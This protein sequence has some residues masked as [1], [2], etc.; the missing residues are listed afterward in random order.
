MNF[1]KK[2]LF[3]F[4]KFK[5]IGLSSCIIGA[6]WLLSGNI[7]SA[8]EISNNSNDS[9]LNPI[10]ND[11]K[12]ENFDNN[13]ETN[14]NSNLNES[15]TAFF[16]V[17][18]TRSATPSVLSDGYNVTVENTGDN[19]SL[20]ISIDNGKDIVSGDKIIFDMTN[21]IQGPPVNSRSIVIGD[22][23]VAT[24]SV[25]NE[26]N[27][28]L[29]HSFNDKYKQS[30]LSAMTKDDALQ[31]IT[32]QL[33]RVH[34]SNL[35]LTF[36]EGINNYNENRRLNIS[37]NETPSTALPRAI[38]PAIDESGNRV[39]NVYANETIRKE[40]ESHL[41][42]EKQRLD[43]S[44]YATLSHNG[45]ELYK[46]KL[47]AY[48]SDFGRA[49]ASN[50][51]VSPI[52][53]VYHTQLGRENIQD[54]FISEIKGGFGGTAFFFNDRLI[55]IDASSL[56]EGAR[57]NAEEIVIT[58]RVDDNSAYETQDSVVDKIVSDYKRNV[59]ATTYDKSDDTTIV[60][61]RPQMKPT[62][63]K[64]DWTV[65][66]IDSNTIKIKNKNEF[67]VNEN[68]ASRFLTLTYQDYSKLFKRKDNWYDYINLD[69]K[70]GIGNLTVGVSDGK[71]DKRATQPTFN[72]EFVNRGYGDATRG[73]IIARH[74]NE[75]G[76]L[77]REVTVL[78]NELW[79]TK[80][81][82]TAPEIENYTFKGLKS[83]SV[84]KLSG[85]AGSGT[86][87][88][89]LEYT[90]NVTEE[91]EPVPFDTIYVRND[92]QPSGYENEVTPGQDGEITYR[93]T[94][95]QRDNG[96]VTT[97]KVDRV[98]EKGTQPKVERNEELPKTIYR[99]NN[100][101]PEGQEKEVDAGRSKV[102]T[103]TTTYNLDPKT[104]IVTPND[105]Q[106][107]VEE[108]SP[109]I[110][111][112]GTQPKVERNEEPPTV[113]YVSNPNLP[114]GS[115]NETYPG[116]PKVTTTTTTYEVDPDTGNVTPSTNTEVTP[117]RPRVVEKGTQPKVERNEELPKTI[118][119]GNNDI[120]EG[121]EKEVDAGR[122][123]VTTTTTTYNLDPKTG[124]VT[125]NDP[126]VE[127]EECS[128][129]IVEKGTQPKVERN[130]E[131]PTVTYVSN[132]NL[133]EGS[134]NE[135]YPGE[136][137]VTTTTTTYEVDPDTGNV[138][139]STNTEV[140]PGRPRVVEKGTQPKVERNEEPPTVTY[141]SNPN[142]PEGS[143]NETDP[144]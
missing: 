30:G 39:P 11:I 141:V 137:K 132:P 123:K 131:P 10:I 50:S 106:V 43:S 105:P 51:T 92:S 133:P 13:T 42:S 138:T 47:N 7:A 9:S 94:N 28:N 122:S 35:V 54:G 87:Y 8:N 61:A 81:S 126:Q 100:D 93:V 53:N 33:E 49:T 78:D 55:N 25:E 74:Y 99:G 18:E 103:T 118:Y 120:P 104:G 96:E 60:S 5:G 68:D 72:V 144:G 41:N 77:L 14:I 71:T 76:N 44:L 83:T 17:P 82:Y 58:L 111:E 128:P 29:K 75:S 84:A 26:R 97:P 65:E 140:T 130:E 1:N 85:A 107:E 34:K 48:L 102:T 124:I 4:R 109:R 95:G 62:V 69:T 27:E 121:Q 2:Q 91:K 22:T 114:E 21:Y 66:R 139:P 108:G 40:Y 113:T 129:R 16:S 57:F 38:V 32:E 98:V 115:E 134:E 119:R 143:E 80:Y 52:P 20:N 125:P 19:Y 110:V 79:K 116:E 63:D 127:V 142:L 31:S 101:I 89:D 64:I 36:T 37:L 70:K 15:R 12:D 112:K 90:S 135:T 3:S 24:L 45:S 56:R 86:R 23:V 117:G 88:I 46:Q 59:V 73:T 67:I 136:P 6:M